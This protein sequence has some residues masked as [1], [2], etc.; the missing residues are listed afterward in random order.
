MQTQKRY[1]FWHGNAPNTNPTACWEEYSGGRFQ[2]IFR[3][4]EGSVGSVIQTVHPSIPLP[5]LD[6]PM[7]SSE[8][9]KFYARFC[10]PGEVIPTT[11][12]AVGTSL[13]PDE[14][15]GLPDPDKNWEAYENAFYTLVA[16]LVG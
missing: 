2:E 16:K 6:V 14:L 8:M 7:A 13:D 10:F 12:F 11:I 1:G 4:A 15:E 9:G 3:V 5:P